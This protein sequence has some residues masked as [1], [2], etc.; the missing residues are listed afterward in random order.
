MVTDN[1]Q[2]QRLFSGRQ[3]KCKCGAWADSKTEVHSKT[4]PSAI[5]YTLGQ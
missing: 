2:L 1:C 3:M 5:L 4:C